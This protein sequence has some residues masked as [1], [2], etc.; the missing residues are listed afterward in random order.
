[1][2]EIRISIPDMSGD[3]SKR[4]SSLEMAVRSRPSTNISK[5][6]SE[7]RKLV[8]KQD[9]SLDRRLARIEELLSKIPDA[10]KSQGRMVSSKVE[11][12]EFTSEVPKIRKIIGESTS[13]ILDMLS[14]RPM[15]SSDNGMK[16]HMRSMEDSLSK[17]ER[18][19]ERFSLPKNIIIYAQKGQNV[20]PS[21]S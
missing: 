18:R 17:M 21:P 1:M 6:L 19:L 11:A 9:S 4:M 13:Q 15:T 2:Q 3:M 5:D 20:V 8:S 14:E 10:I 7:I 12:I 16:Q